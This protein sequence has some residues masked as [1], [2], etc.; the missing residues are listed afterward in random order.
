MR[1][2]DHALLSWQDY[3]TKA[4][5]MHTSSL[6][7]PLSVSEVAIAVVNSRSA[8]PVSTV[9]ARILLMLPRLPGIRAASV[10]RQLQFYDAI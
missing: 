7:Y 9:E 6:V 1:H 3:R 2:W 5:C 8:S 10:R 4:Q